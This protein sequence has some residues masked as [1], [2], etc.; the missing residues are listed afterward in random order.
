MLRDRRVHRNLKVASSHHKIALLLLKMQEL[1]LKC[2]SRR[3]SK[4]CDLCIAREDVDVA[5]L[6]EPIVVTRRWHGAQVE[7]QVLKC[8]GMNFQSS[9][10]LLATNGKNNS[11]DMVEKL[12][13]RHKVISFLNGDK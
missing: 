12:V 9:K 2:S 1:L 5:L 13:S 4:L 11:I 7:N 10:C 8:I 3:A 6:V